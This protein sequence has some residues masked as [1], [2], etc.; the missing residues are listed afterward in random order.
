M[1][2]VQSLFGKKGSAFSKF[3]TGTLAMLKKLGAQ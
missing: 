2:L 1:S 3:E